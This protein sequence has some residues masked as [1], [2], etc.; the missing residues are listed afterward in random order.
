VKLSIQNRRGAIVHWLHVLSSKVIESGLVAGRSS[1]VE[2]GTAQSTGI[3]HSTEREYSRCGTPV[4][5][6]GVI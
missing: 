1:L 3:G 6:N 2:P 5:A 4:S